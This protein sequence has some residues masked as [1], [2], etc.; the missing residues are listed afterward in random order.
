MINHHGESNGI[1]TSF[2]RKPV[3]PA[4]SFA[5]REDKLDSEFQTAQLDS[6]KRGLPG[7][8][9]VIRNH[10]QAMVKADN[11]AARL[12]E[13]HELYRRIHALTAN[14]GI[15]GLTLIAQIADALE[16]LLKELYEKPKS[17]NAS[18]MRTVA[19]VV[20]FLAILFKNGLDP[21][22][23]EIPSANILVVDDEA[24]SRRAVT[25]ALEKAKLKSVSAED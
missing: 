22:L 21:K 3:S 12:K 19:S 25:Y 5:T 15:V 7:S 23:Q 16:A 4:S 6:F 11:E 8:V 10:L 18:T 2:I 9:S 13:V 24:I 17:L 14:S 1:I 20:D